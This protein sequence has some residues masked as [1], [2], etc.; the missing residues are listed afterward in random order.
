[1]SQPGA[2]KSVNRTYASLVRQADPNF[3]ADKR[4]QVEYEFSNDRKFTGNPA[5]RG[6]YA[7]EED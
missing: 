6:A 4:N 3:E 7:P 5:R 1:M 2:T